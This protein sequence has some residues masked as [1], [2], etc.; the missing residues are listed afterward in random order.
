[1]P[2]S[3]SMFLGEMEILCAY[4]LLADFVNGRW[5][6]QLVHKCLLKRWRRVRYWDRKQRRYAGWWHVAVNHRWQ[7]GSCWSFFLGCFIGVA[8]GK[9]GKKYP[10][11]VPKKCV[12]MH[13][14]ILR[15]PQL[16]YRAD[17]WFPLV[18]ELSD[19]GPLLLFIVDGWIAVVRFPG[20]TC[21]VCVSA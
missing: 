3:V 16:S 2:V 20:E 21:I 10:F 19:N 8:Y 6:I 17:P 1:M 15:Q 18:Q 9:W 11:I 4:G 5:A 13:R 14:T 7:M 12:R